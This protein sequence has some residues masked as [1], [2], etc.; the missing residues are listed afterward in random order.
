M[1]NDNYYVFLD[2]CYLI[3]IIVSPLIFK[4][5]YSSFNYFVLLQ[6]AWI[7]WLQRHLFCN[8]TLDCL[9]R[10]VS[11]PG[12]CLR[13]TS[14]LLHRTLTACHTRS[15]SPHLRC[16]YWLYGHHLNCKQRHAWRS[17]L[18]HTT[19]LLRVFF[20]VLGVVFMDECST[21]DTMPVGIRRPE[22]CYFVKVKYQCQHTNV[23][24]FT[25]K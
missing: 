10:Q 16:C 21:R 15:P 7:F 25:T 12:L 17:C 9:P 3:Y 18:L 2:N 20:H 11:V 23:V 13:V 6:A 1:F 8:F 14:G 4:S 5:F 22:N 19:C 24:S